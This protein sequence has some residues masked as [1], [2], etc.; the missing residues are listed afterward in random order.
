MTVTAASSSS[1]NDGAAALVMMRESTAKKLG[2]KP[3]ARIVAHATHAQE[4]EWFATAPAGA[5]R[6]AL[7]QAGWQ[8]Q[9]VDLWEV[10]EAFAA[11]VMRFMKEMKVPHDKVNVNGGAIA[12]DNLF[13]AY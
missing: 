10:N 5:I 7:A 11:V 12:M 6:K 8:A 2:V 1:I 13:L 4:P 9:Q 3:L